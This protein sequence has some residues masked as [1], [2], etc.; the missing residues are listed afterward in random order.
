M[1]C[2]HC[3]TST[4]S[5]STLTPAGREPCRRGWSLAFWPR[6]ARTFTV[7]ECSRMITGSNKPRAAFEVQVHP[8]WRLL[9]ALTV[10]QVFWMREWESVKASESH[11]FT[12]KFSEEAAERSCLQLPWWGQ[13]STPPFGFQVWFVSSGAIQVMKSEDEF[14]HSLLSAS[15]F[16]DC[17][18]LGVRN[19]AGKKAR[20]KKS[21]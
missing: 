16:F 21:L 11:T 1:I 9:K 7:G 17:G 12:P 4:L 5:V 14:Q 19:K 8:G 6:Y 18:G 15:C 20:K 3:L 13:E 10:R 2:S